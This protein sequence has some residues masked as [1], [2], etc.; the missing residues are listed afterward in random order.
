MKGSFCVSTVSIVCSRMLGR[1][2]IRSGGD[3]LHCRGAIS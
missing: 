3:P 1:L 2:P